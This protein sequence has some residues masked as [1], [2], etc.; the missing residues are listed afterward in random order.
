MAWEAALL[1]AHH[2][3]AKVDRKLRT[4]EFDLSEREALN[5][6]FHDALVAACDSRWLLAMRKVMYDQHARYRAV[7]LT[8]TRKRGAVRD[9]A[10]EHDAIVK[11][12]LARQHRRAASLVEDHVRATA[13][14]LKQTLAAHLVT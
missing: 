1:A 14:L 12:A 6:S 8:E 10:A 5:S 9:V 11:A 3:V 2:L 13:T 4:N 7:A